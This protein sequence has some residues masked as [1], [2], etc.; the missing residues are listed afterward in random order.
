M[1]EDKHTISN[2]LSS[3]TMENY[4]RNI[5][6][7]KYSLVLGN[8]VM[9]FARWRE[10]ECYH[11]W[12]INEITVWGSVSEI[13]YL[14]DQYFIFSTQKDQLYFLHVYM[15]NFRC[16]ISRNIM[17]PRVSH[18]A[19]FTGGTVC[20]ICWTL[21]E[22]EK[23]STFV[24]KLHEMKIIWLFYGRGGGTKNQLPRGGKPPAL[25]PQL[26]YKILNEG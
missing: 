19:L 3:L 22:N 6:C 24:W 16:T 26:I 4:A 18:M 2:F 7:W 8:S 13:I 12:G 9:N 5:C 21:H 14:S 20:K 11:F 15:L 10:L 25:H 23:K 17:R 1:C